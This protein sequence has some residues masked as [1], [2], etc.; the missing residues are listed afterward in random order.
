MSS[1]VAWTLKV[2]RLGGAVSEKVPVFEDPEGVGWCMSAYYHPSLK[3]IILTTQHTGNAS[4]LLGIFDAPTPWGPWTT[5]KYFEPSNAFGAVREGSELTWEQN[6]FFA[7]FLTKWLHRDKFTL[8]FT[9]AGR[10]RDND[11]FNTVQGRFLL[12]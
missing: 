7:A 11:S 3:R 1:L 12:R 4:G 8:N 2:M 9:W 6:I 10:G 5:V